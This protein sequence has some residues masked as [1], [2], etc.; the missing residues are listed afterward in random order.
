MFSLGWTHCIYLRFS[1]SVRK[2]RESILPK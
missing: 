2:S 1:S